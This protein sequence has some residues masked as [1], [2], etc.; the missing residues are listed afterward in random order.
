MRSS[1]R[2]SEGTITSW[3]DGAARIFGYRAEEMMGTSIMR[4]IPPDLHSEEEQIL[5]RLRRGERIEHFETVR[6]TKDGRT[7]DI[8][9]TVSPLRDGSGRVVGASKVARDITERK[10]G[11]EIQRLLF[12]ELN[13]RVKN[14]LATIQAIAA[15]SLRRAA[16]PAS[17]VAGFSGR[18]QALARAHDLLVE[19]ELRGAAVAGLVREQVLLGAA[20][21]RVQAAGPEVTL[22]ARSTVQLALVLHELATNARKH[23][24][25]SI[26]GGRLVIEWTL[27]VDRAPRLALTWTESGLR[28]VRAPNGQGF[29]TVL[30]QR[31][32]EAAG[33]SARVVYGPT[34]LVCH[35]ELPLPVDPVSIPHAPVEQAQQAARAAEYPSGPIEGLRILIVEDEPLVA[36]DLEAILAAEDC[37]VLGPA[38]SV[39]RALAL[40]EA[41]PP[42]AAVLDANLSG[43]SVEAVAD[44]LVARGIP[45]AFATGYG[46]EALPARHRAAP[47]LAKPFAPAA[48]IA[49]VAALVA[50]KEA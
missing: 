10:R 1:A 37:A 13:H 28:D 12:D 27:A 47:V 8:S 16:D 31:S 42:D 15:Q 2:L 48:L 30:I 4:L 45:F 5:A 38:P 24:A 39:A 41:D 18:V 50:P 20:D 9:L 33:G 44:A 21:A 49:V 17:F 34:G 32:L 3:N 29:G 25:L 7:I 35:L 22:D 19:G 26:A 14:T 40:L 6:V 11:E 23:G 46:R 43:D 36:M